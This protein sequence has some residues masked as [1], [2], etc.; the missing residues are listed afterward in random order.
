M[1]TNHSKYLSIFAAAALLAISLS[2]C[3]GGGGGGSSGPAT[4]EDDMPDGGTSQ[5]S[6]SDIVAAANTQI[7]T[8]SGP[9]VSPVYADVTCGAPGSGPA[10]A[11]GLSCTLNFG[12]GIT[13]PYVSP[14]LLLGTIDDN[15]D[16]QNL[17]IP[18]SIDRNGVELRVLD[19]AGSGEELGFDVSGFGRYVFGILEHSA[20]M[21]GS[22]TTGGELVASGF[23]ASKTYQTG[24][25]GD[26]PNSNPTIS[27]TWEG[28]F[29]GFWSGQGPYEGNT[30]VG[31]STISING[32]GGSN[33]T[34]N[35]SLDDLVYLVET[36][37]AVASADVNGMR[38]RNGAFEDSTGRVRG[39]FYGPQHEEVA[40]AYNRNGLAGAFGATRE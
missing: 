37:H 5:T 23:L 7:M 28:V 36:R 40:G 8:T 3:G 39:N 33:P 26:A 21:T 4:G 34:V 11:P 9:G 15:Q 24:V 38:L 20:F 35:L 14:E 16:V 10:H 17:S 12:Q 18:S 1:S 22:G 31:E 6:V 25:L 2:A 32:L 13:I 30:I 29:A 19:Y 27:A